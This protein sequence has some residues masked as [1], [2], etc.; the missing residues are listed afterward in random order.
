MAACLYRAFHLL[1]SEIL[2]SCCGM[3]VVGMVG[4]RRRSARCWL[5]GLLSPHRLHTRSTC[6]A[7]AHCH[8][9][10]R[11][12]RAFT[13]AQLRR[14]YNCD[15]TLQLTVVVTHAGAHCALRAFSH[16]TYIPRSR[17]LALRCLPHTLNA[18][19]MAHRCRTTH[20]PAILTRTRATHHTCPCRRYYPPYHPFAARYYAACGLP[21]PSSSCHLRSYSSTYHACLTRAYAHTACRTPPA[22]GAPIPTRAT[23]GGYTISGRSGLRGMAD[24]GPFAA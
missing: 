21:S 8:H 7:R 16:A 20:A 12:A 3:T 9:L 5:V 23:T 24:N 1:Q 17:T 6:R 19:N 4:G 13:P 22:R 14:G 15:C 18:H 10:S 11:R 2:T